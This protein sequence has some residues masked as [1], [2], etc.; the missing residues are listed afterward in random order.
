MLLLLGLGGAIP[1]RGRRTVY[2]LVGGAVLAFVLSFGPNLSVFGA[3][4]YALVHQFY[5]GF[6]KLRTPWRFAAFSQVFLV[7]LAGISLGELWRRGWRAAAAIVVV[8]AVVETTSPGR[9]LHAY[10]GEALKEAW[11]ERLVQA[12]PA[13]IVM[14]PVARSPKA[15]HHHAEVVG[16]LRALEHG[17]PLVEGYSGFAPPHVQ[18]L[19]HVVRGAPPDVAV[20]ALAD[21]GVG[22]IVVARR[23]LRPRREQA[24][25]A[26][27]R[28]DLVYE[29]PAKRIYRLQ[30]P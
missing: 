2:F 16:M 12:E 1:G 6:D 26:D 20:S 5:P 19:R 14:L 30:L 23:G 24:L 25:A 29:G 15:S 27:P 9:R 8:L 3:K 11:I 22:Y 13:P 17:K 21:L 4:P 28:V 7:A 18:E 10:A